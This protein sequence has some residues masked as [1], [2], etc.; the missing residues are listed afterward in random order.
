MS[1]CRGDFTNL[2]YCGK[3]IDYL[4]IHSV[5]VTRIPLFPVGFALQ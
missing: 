4:V 1:V 3:K 5:S 2:D